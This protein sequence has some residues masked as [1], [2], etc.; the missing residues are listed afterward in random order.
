MNLKLE[1]VI[2]YKNSISK[3][4]FVYTIICKLFGT[5]KQQNETK[6][7]P[8]KTYTHSKSNEIVQIMTS[9]N[10]ATGLIAKLD[11]DVL[12]RLILRNPLA[13]AVV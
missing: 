7:K 6:L 8:K 11:I 1:N 5:S 13:L 2:S 9:F 10:T 3:F 4:F 12:F